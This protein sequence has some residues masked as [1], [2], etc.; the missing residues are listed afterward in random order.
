MV[1]KKNY[2]GQSYGTHFSID[3]NHRKSNAKRLGP[4]GEY[5]QKEYTFKYS[6]FR[7]I[8]QGVPCESKKRVF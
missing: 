8:C 6:L 4:L 5:S 1:L 3:K 2:I 7:V